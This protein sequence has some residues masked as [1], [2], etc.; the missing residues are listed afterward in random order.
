MNM[1]LKFLIPGFENFFK[2]SHDS[3]EINI[4]NKFTLPA[5]ENDKTDSIIK[6]QAKEAGLEEGAPIEDGSISHM[7]EKQDLIGEGISSEKNVDP[8]NV[9]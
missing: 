5:N 3:N 6:E 1:N 2:E 8:G 4:K 9:Q 7:D